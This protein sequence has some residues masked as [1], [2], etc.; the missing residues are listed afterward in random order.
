MRNCAKENFLRPCSK[1]LPVLMQLSQIAKT[2]QTRKWNQ[3]VWKRHGGSWVSHVPLQKFDMKTEAGTSM[4]VPIDITGSWWVSLLV[5]VSSVP[6]A[7][8][9]WN[10]NRK[11]N[12]EESN[13]T[14]SAPKSTDRSFTSIQMVHTHAS[15]PRGYFLPFA[16]WFGKLLLVPWSW[17]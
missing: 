4:S 6:P 17:M 12:H 8:P 14:S 10:W 13:K 9:A 7:P 11:I 2:V 16:E 15:L 5:P 1:V 3:I